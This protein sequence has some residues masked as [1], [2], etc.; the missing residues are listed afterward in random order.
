MDPTH[1]FTMA[2]SGTPLSR[3]RGETPKAQAIQGAMSIFSGSQ[4][5]LAAFTSS[6]GELAGTVRRALVDDRR[7]VWKDTVADLVQCEAKAAHQWTHLP[8]S[9][10]G[11]TPTTP[12]SHSTRSRVC[13]L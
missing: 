6:L 5:A 13:A 8:T 7:Q 11:R 10:V 2:F 3:A 12:R 9:I 1:D 4:A